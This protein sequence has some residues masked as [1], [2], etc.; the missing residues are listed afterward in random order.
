MKID[1]PLDR[2]AFFKVAGTAAGGLLIALHLD[3]AWGGETAPP[4]AA[5]EAAAKPF[6]PNAFVEISAD[7]TV[8]LWAKNPE[9]GQGIKT[10]LPMIVAEE[11]GADWSRVRV[12]QADYDPGRYGSQ[13]AGGSSGVSDNWRRLRQA[14]ATAREMLLSAAAAAWGVDR[15]GC[16][17]E[18]GAVVHRASG[19][20]LSFGE[21][22]AAAALQAV[23]DSVPLKDPKDFS[24]L[25]TR[26]KGVDNPLIVT[27]KAQFGVDVRLP[28]MLHAAVVLPP[29]VGSRVVRFD[30]RRAMKVPG[31]R[32]VVRI[33]PLENPTY[34]FP[35]VGVIA[36]STWAARKGKEALTVEWDTREGKGESTESLRRQC[37]EL[38]AGPGKILRR[39]GD[40]E[41]ALAGSRRRLSADYEVPFLAHA[42]L[43]PVNCTADVRDGRCELWGPFQNPGPARQLAARVTGLPEDAVTV[44]MTRLG[45]GFGRRLLSDFAPQAAV[46]SKAVGA[47][48]QVLWSREDDMRH[49]F[50][51]P[52]G[53]HRMEAGLDDQ[54]RLTV[55]RHHVVNA[56]RY[57]FRLDPGPPE[58]S[59]V[60]VDDFPA[61]FVPNFELA[62]S[63][64]RTSIP[65]GPWRATL[66]SANAFAIQCFLDEIAHAAGRDPLELRLDLLGAPR[67][68]PYEQHG[69]P[70]F[71][72]GRMRA[73][74]ELAAEK[75]GWGKA[76]PAGHGLGIASNFTFG[77]YA[78]HVAEVSVDQGRVKVHRL[79]AAVDCGIVINASGA[80]AQASGAT[81]DGLNAALQGEITVA[82]GGV[83]EGN[84]DQYPC[85]TLGE[86]PPVEIFLVKSD[87]SPR[88]MGEIALPPV[89]PAV[90]NALFA[91]T[92]QR[93]RRLPLRR[94]E[95]AF[96]EA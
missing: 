62:Y 9:M 79:V 69:G 10:S 28:G 30:D 11:L 60:F 27:G 19:R 44:H 36:D 42:A 84:F 29:V 26:V 17:A 72:T 8:T 61:G 16:A 93:V 57:A 85:L 34:L 76:L 35:G 1:A 68:V 55:W 71:S 88:G 51:R 43:E 18:N 53:L 7:D 63:L 47:P 83:V 58:A 21:L 77:S 67:D 74:L 82:D 25:G 49:D 89:A 48:V 59:E 5:A 40:P 92:G 32:K 24:L 45:G 22:A 3:A 54:G 64:A 52:A 78:A 38:A 50:Y 90:A 15:T 31:V 96:P 81:I 91:A 41:A 73:V 65:T 14:G 86:V 6:S 66:Q 46:L 13:D 4:A 12:L 23:P 20:R 75:A 95:F 33:D 56:S 94:H 2:R 87:K 39:E 80:E 37:R 70:V